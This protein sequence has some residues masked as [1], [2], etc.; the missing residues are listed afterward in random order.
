MNEPTANITLLAGAWLWQ[1]ALNARKI[2]VPIHG[3]SIIREGTLPGWMLVR[4][5]DG[6]TREVGKRFI[7][8][9][10]L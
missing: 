7:E 2:L 1:S 6:R 5:P 3:A 10:A 9:S 8:T 4:L